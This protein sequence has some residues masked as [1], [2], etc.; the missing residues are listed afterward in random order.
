MRRRKWKDP[1]RRC[2]TQMGNPACKLLDWAP[3]RLALAALSFVNSL[4]LLLWAVWIW[5]SPTS[6]FRLDFSPIPMRDA[7]D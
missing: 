5:S 6:H 7:T 2:G 4:L 3:C 1:L